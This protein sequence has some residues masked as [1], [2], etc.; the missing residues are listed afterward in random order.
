MKSK[1]FLTIQG[2]EIVNQDGQ[3]VNLR[4]FG[5]GGLCPKTRT[6]WH[7]GK[8]LTT[9]KFVQSLNSLSNLTGIH[10]KKEPLTDESTETQLSL[11]HG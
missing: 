10:C 5:L 8:L 1:H 6:G 11:H 3:I 9:K 7:P 4:G 2:T